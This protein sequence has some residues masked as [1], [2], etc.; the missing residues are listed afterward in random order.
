MVG[1]Y[2]EGFKFPREFP[3]DTALPLVEY[4]F[5]RFP[6]S[7]TEFIEVTYFS[8]GEEERSV[9]RHSH[10]VCCVL[11]NSKGRRSWPRNLSNI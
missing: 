3:N 1:N 6:N 10:T 11:K 9:Y 4:Y 8:L 5:K 2:I 7:R